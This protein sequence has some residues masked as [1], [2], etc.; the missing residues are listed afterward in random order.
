MS[1]TQ[2]LS[3]D[4][5]DLTNV[6]SSCF[7]SCWRKDAGCNPTLSLDFFHF[8]GSSSQSSTVFPVSPFSPISNLA[9]PPVAAPVSSIAWRRE[10]LDTDVEYVPLP[11]QY[12]LHSPLSAEG[13]KSCSK[14]NFMTAAE[15]ATTSDYLPRSSFVSVSLSRLLLCKNIFAKLLI[16]RFLVLKANHQSKDFLPLLS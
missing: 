11:P 4:R 10:L 9:Y 8:W 13:R 3:Q 5:L 6:F 1:R 16:P 7:W 12:I 15:K 14:E 2:L